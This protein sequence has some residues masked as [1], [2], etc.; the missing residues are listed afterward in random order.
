MNKTVQF[1]VGTFGVAVVAALVTVGTFALKSYNHGLIA[2]EVT[3]QNAP[4]AETLQRNT[5]ALEGIQ[6]AAQLETDRELIT[7]CE[8][9]A[10]TDCKRESDWRWE[11][12]FPW[13]ECAAQFKTPKERVDACGPKPVY[14]AN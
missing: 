13:V 10:R 2:Q 4:M 11:E 7:E 5:A 3:E 12:F 9:A 8:A 6:F 14:D 1:I